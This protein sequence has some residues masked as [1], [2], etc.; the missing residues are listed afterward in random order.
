MFQH[1]H[2]FEQVLSHTVHLGPVIHVTG[3][4]HPALHFSDGAGLSLKLPAFVQDRITASGA[5]QWILPAFSPWAGGG[6]YENKKHERIA[7]WACGEGR[8]LRT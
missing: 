6:L 3:H 8:I 1:G 4:E 7:A 5:E 2:R